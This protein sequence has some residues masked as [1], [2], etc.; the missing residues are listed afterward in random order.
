M[1]PLRAQIEALNLYLIDHVVV[2]DEYIAIVFKCFQ[3]FQDM[4]SHVRLSSVRQQCVELAPKAF[5]T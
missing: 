4:F 2:S 3:D 1:T 5:N